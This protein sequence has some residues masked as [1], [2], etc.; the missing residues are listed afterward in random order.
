LSNKYKISFTSDIPFIP[1]T[2][3]HVYIHNHTQKFYNIHIL[4]LFWTIFFFKITMVRILA[5]LRTTFVQDHTTIQSD[6][7]K[8]KSGHSG[9]LP[10]YG[11]ARAMLWSFMLKRNAI[12][13][14]QKLQTRKKVAQ[15]LFTKQCKFFKNS[16]KI[17]FYILKIFARFFD[18]LLLNHLTCCMCILGNHTISNWQSRNYQYFLASFCVCHCCH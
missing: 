13:D 10:S 12:L 18:T 5:Y 1:Y 14:L 16:W 9:L 7:M 2:Y 4:D 3:R 11:T 15:N 8:G 6:T 17:N